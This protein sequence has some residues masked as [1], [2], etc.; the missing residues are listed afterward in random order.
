MPSVHSPNDCNNLMLGPQSRSC[1][2][3]VRTQ[4]ALLPPLDPAAKLRPEPGSPAWDAGVSD[5]I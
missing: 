5:G 1:K 2:S 4:L 3:V